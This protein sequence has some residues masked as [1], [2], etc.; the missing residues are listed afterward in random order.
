VYLAAVLEYLC[1]EVLELGGY[2]GRSNQSECI[3]PRHLMLAIANDPELRM[4]F[5]HVVV[6]GGG[7]A[8]NIHCGLMEQLSAQAKAGRGLVRRGDPA[9]PPPDHTAAVELVCDLCLE[10]GEAEATHRC[11]SCGDDLCPKHVVQHGRSKKK[12]GHLLTSAAAP[13]PLAPPPLPIQPSSLTAA[14]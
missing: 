3:G 1:A 14:G 7:V 5:D 10:G 4:M 6:I 9:P 11:Q 8:P 2:A 12:K 13:L